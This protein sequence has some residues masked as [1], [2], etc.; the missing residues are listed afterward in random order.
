V[1]HG[2]PGEDLGLPS[3]LPVDIG[4]DGACTPLLDV[5]FGQSAPAGTLDAGIYEA[6]V[7]LANGAPCSGTLAVA[8]DVAIPV[9][10]TVIVV[11]HLDQN[12]VPTLSSFTA[13]VDD[14]GTGLA[15]VQVGHTA[16]APA[17]D[18]QLK[19]KGPNARVRDLGP[20][21]QSFAAQL[22][23]NPYT[24]QIRPASGGKPVLKL[25]GVTFTGDAYTAV[26]AVGSPTSGTFTLAT[27]EISP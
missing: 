11:A 18:V 1:L 15:K 23:T 13:N 20:G 8:A 26:F 16:A 3:T 24:V 27:V 9:A 14:I 25:S 12:G 17:V 10:G 21:E 22:L 6:Q 2:I 4:L 19:G 5:E 7:Y